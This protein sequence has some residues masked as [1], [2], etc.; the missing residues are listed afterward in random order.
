MATLETAIARI[1]SLARGLPGMKQAPSLPPEQ[2]ASYPF[3]VCFPLRG[4]WSAQSDGWLIGLHT[5]AAEIHIARRDLPIDVDVAL[6]FIESFP[7]AIL[8]DPTLNGNVQTVNDIRYTFGPMAWG[9]QATIGW[10]FE[11]DVKAMLVIT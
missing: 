11:I 4:A 7:A 6:P 5:I 1:Q 8:S 2:A 10:R 3:C 9:G